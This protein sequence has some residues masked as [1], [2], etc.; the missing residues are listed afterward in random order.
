MREKEGEILAKKAL[1]E[2][3]EKIH[4]DIGAGAQGRNSRIPEKVWIEKDGGASYV[5]YAYNPEGRPNHAVSSSLVLTRFMRIA[6]EPSPDDAV[7]A[8]AKT[9]GVLGICEHPGYRRPGYDSGVLPGR[10]FGR[11]APE[12]V[13][14]SEAIY[15]RNQGRV[16]SLADSPSLQSIVSSCRQLV[17]LYGYYGPLHDIL[18]KQLEDADAIFAREPI[19]GWVNY[20]RMLSAIV[21]TLITAQGDDRVLSRAVICDALFPSRDNPWTLRNNPPWMTEEQLEM[22]RQL[23]LGLEPS[24]VAE[25]ALMSWLE[26]ETTPTV[27][28]VWRK[29]GEQHLSAFRP[30]IDA[31]GLFGILTVQLLAA[32]TT[33]KSASLCDCCGNPF[34]VNL[35]EEDE[36]RPP[37][38]KN[39]FCR[40]CRDDNHRVLQAFV[41]RQR[42]AAKNPT[43]KNN[44]RYRAKTAPKRDAQP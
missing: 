25:Q 30:R 11:G 24:Q 32:A 21:Q 8:F 3:R 37:S 29:K 26:V 35:A 10:M 7:L 42:Y 20:A 23:V 15:T 18:G 13:E 17:E 43:A 22:D 16:R 4:V 36:R 31:P 5:R 12:C 27:G 40:V 33:P 44:S 14:C 6:S 41:Q 9:Y 39:N 34:T 38:G 2:A 1:Q 28:G 19:E